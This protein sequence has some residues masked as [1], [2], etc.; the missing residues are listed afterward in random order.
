M[1]EWDLVL[2]QVPLLLIASS[3][4]ACLS[5][6]IALPAFYFCCPGPMRQWWSLCFYLYQIFF[7]ESCFLLWLLK[8]RNPDKWVLSVLVLKS[9]DCKCVPM[10]VRILHKLPGKWS[11]FFKVINEKFK[12]WLHDWKLLLLWICPY[13]RIPVMNNINRRSC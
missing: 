12:D 11:F 8:N 4:S 6:H 10:R 2:V 1:L 7:L 5:T 3:F 13:L 9:L